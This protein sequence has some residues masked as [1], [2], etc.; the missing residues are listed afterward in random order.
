MTLLRIRTPSSSMLLSRHRL[1]VTWATPS[2]SGRP[3]AVT[4]CP[5]CV[6]ATCWPTARPASTSALQRAR[7][8]RSKRGASDGPQMRPAADAAAPLLAHDPRLVARID[9]FCAYRCAYR[10]VS[11]QCISVQFAAATNRVICSTCL[12]QLVGASRP[13]LLIPRSQV[14]SL[15][16][17]SKDP[18]NRRLLSSGK[19]RAARMGVRGSC[20][21]RW[22]RRDAH[23]L[24]KAAVR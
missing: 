11:A 18:A 17:P 5:N 24:T 9:S 13:G 10:L 3:S 8:Q 22:I 2:T 7:R 4:R 6:S 20:R 1:V 21:L 12:L 15:P 19:A 16:G 14:R 23:V